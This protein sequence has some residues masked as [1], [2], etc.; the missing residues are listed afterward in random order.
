MIHCQTIR[1]QPLSK[2]KFSCVRLTLKFVWKHFTSGSNHLHSAF[3]TKGCSC[4]SQFGEKH[5][6]GRSLPMLIKHTVN[7]CCCS[8]YDQTRDEISVSIQHYDEST[9]PTVRSEHS[10]HKSFQFG[11]I[12]GITNI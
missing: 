8:L 7:H 12:K 3:H 2:V 1:Q 10:P 11:N 9:I 4:T 5:G 6:R